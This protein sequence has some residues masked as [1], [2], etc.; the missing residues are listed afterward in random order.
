MRFPNPKLVQVE[1]P[2]RSPRESEIEREGTRLPT[3][4]KSDRLLSQLLLGKS[5][6]NFELVSFLFG[7]RDETFF[8]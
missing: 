5:L 4:R 3:R 7:D 1:I 2:G 8:L 6:Q